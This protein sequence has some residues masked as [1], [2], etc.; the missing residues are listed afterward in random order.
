[1]VTQDSLLVTL[2]KLVDRLPQPVSPV[3]RGRGHP[4]VYSNQLFLKAVVIMIIRHLRTVHEL[5]G[6]LAEPTPEMCQLRELLCEQGG[7]PTRR[8]WER[9]LK[10]LPETLPAQIGCLG[11]YLIERIS[12]WQKRGRA[13]A[14]DSTVL[15]SRGAVWHQKHRKTGEVPHTLIDTE[16]HWTK[17]GWHGW[18]YGWKLHVVSVVAGVW[19]PVAALLTPANVADNTPAP[20]LLREVP[21]DVR[22]VLGDRH[23]N[24]PEIREDC[25]LSGRTLV[26]T[27]LGSYPHTDDGVEVRRVFHKLRSIAMEN[28]N[29][30]FKSIFD[31][32]GQVPTK[33]LIATQRFVLGAIF[34]YQL[35]LLY[36][37]EQGLD[38]CV[39]LKA[40]LKGA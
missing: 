40:F 31:G 4:Q 25:A 39:G 9:R 12:P 35:A 21:A 22:F 28:F 1:M 10:S 17:S 27:Q 29:Q 11:R 30:H 34:V 3:K 7:F 6:V 38:L 5:L 32:H 14:I 24:T 36:R 26:A 15:R 2:V 16:A 23:Y 33:G 18:V 13:V 8:T 37:W 20:A 19:F